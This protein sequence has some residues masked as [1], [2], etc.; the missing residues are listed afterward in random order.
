MATL[1]HRCGTEI[2]PREGPGRP[3]LWCSDECRRLAH[4]ERR[5]ARDGGQPIEI[6]EEI[7][8]R[9]VERSRPLSPDGA[10]ERVLGD[11]EAT[12]KL[13]WVLAHRWRHDPPTT[14][15]QRWTHSRYKPIVADLWQAWHDARDEAPT[16]PPK[17]TVAVPAGRAEA[18]RQAVTLVLESPR[19]LREIM[20]T[21]TTRARDGELARGEY[22]ATVSAAG[23]LYTTLVASR[24]LRPR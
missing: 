6:R 5:V 17:V 23:E 20:T 8:E 7:R 14:D 1:C 24:T 19:A 10:I 9:I 21:L 12:L 16:T 22:T 13:L 18:L 4:E 3:R 2:P 11:D 15:T